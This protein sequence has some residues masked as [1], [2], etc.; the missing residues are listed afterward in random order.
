LAAGLRPNPLGE[1]TA[2][3]QIPW[4]DSEGSGGIRGMEEGEER[5]RMG[6]EGEGWEREGR[7]REGSDRPANFLGCFRRL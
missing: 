2:L 1:L 3:S 4:L 7:N 5:G 6:R